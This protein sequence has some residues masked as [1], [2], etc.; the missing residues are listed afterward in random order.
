[1]S[2]SVK[3][4]SV[5]INGILSEQFHIEINGSAFTM[6]G[7]SLSQTLLNPC[8]LSFGLQKDTDE[9]AEDVNFKVCQDIIGQNIALVLQTEAMEVD[10]EGYEDDGQQ[11]GTIEFKGFIVSANASRSGS[12]Y[13]ISVEAL[14]HDARMQTMPHCY[15]YNDYQLKD[16]IKEHMADYEGFLIEL[17]GEVA[18][19]RQIHYTVQYNE[20][21]YEFMQRL[22][23]RHQE[24]M[25]STGT[26][27]HFGKL[28]DQESIK[29]TYPS[30][31]LGDYSVDLKTQHMDYYMF[32]HIYNAVGGT[33]HVWGKRFDNKY[34]LATETNGNFLSDT[35]YGASIN[36]YPKVTLMMLPGQGMEGDAELKAAIE[37]KDYSM[38][39]TTLNNGTVIRDSIRANLVH[40][41]GGSTCARLKIGTKLTIMDDFISGEN[42]QKNEVQQDEILITAVYHSF[43]VNGNYSNSFE[44]VPSTINYPPYQHPRTYPRCD[45]PVHAIVVDNEDPEHLGRVRVRFSWQRQEFDGKHGNKEKNGMT[46]WIHMAQ[47]YTGSLEEFDSLGGVFI[48]PEIFSG[49]M[50]E[51]EEGNYERPI[52][53]CCYPNVQAPIDKKWY[54]GW[55]NVKAIRT[56]S[57]HTIEIHDTEDE[58]KYGK[59]GYIKV[60]DNKLHTYELLLSTDRSLIKLRSAGNIELDAGKDIIMN[61]KDNIKM[62]TK[63][64]DIIAKA[65]NIN[66]DASLQ[67]NMNAGSSIKEEAKIGIDLIAKM[68]FQLKSPEG[69]GQIETK[70]WMF[71]HSMDW[72]QMTANKDMAIRSDSNISVRSLDDLDLHSGTD[73]TIDPAGNL[74]IKP[75]TNLE[76]YAAQFKMSVSGTGGISF[77]GPLD[78]TGMPGSYH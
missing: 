52:V 76:M 23:M 28:E 29:L 5:S 65:R 70:Q 49:V 48:L 53:S 66:T 62:T 26:K 59:K 40:Y 58:N 41:R 4:I 64:Q 19:Q 17:E 2:V 1:M 68:G 35:A 20:S 74:T 11:I 71:V 21:D 13:Y 44:G 39:Y 32:G 42:S 37:K 54:P 57:G 67:I 43:G 45:H 46:P 34:A 10:L 61:A 33:G 78:V 9:N 60:Y 30:E 77:N 16:I 31:N 25:F 55:N 3:S 8:R 63:Y 73:T 56:A 69:W 22:A 6:Q 51:F 12:D 18:T 7:F 27:L 14:S 47:P 50:V 24:W 75:T 72:L 36:N 38:Y 15:M